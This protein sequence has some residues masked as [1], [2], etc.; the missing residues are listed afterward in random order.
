MS[1]ADRIELGKELLNELEAKNIPVNDNL[2]NDLEH[3]VPKAIV[4]AEKKLANAETNDEAEQ[5]VKPAEEATQSIAKNE[6]AENVTKQ[7][8]KA[9]KSA[10]EDTVLKGVSGIYESDIKD[11][12]DRG[13]NIESY[14]GHLENGKP[15][16][17]LDFE[18]SDDKA[19][20]V[21]DFYSESEEIDTDTSE[22]DYAK[23]LD[24]EQEKK[25]GAEPAEEGN[26]KAT[27]EDGKRSEEQNI[28][29]GLK[30]MEAKKR[31]HEA[32]EKQFT[33]RINTPAPKN[34]P[35]TPEA[36]KEGMNLEYN[37]LQQV[38]K[39]RRA[40]DEEQISYQ[41]AQEKLNAI[42]KTATNTD[43][44]VEDTYTSSNG[45]EKEYTRKSG[46]LEEIKHEKEFL[47]NEH[48]RRH[49]EIEE[50]EKQDR[51]KQENNKYH[52][53][54]DNVS[55]R[56]RGSIIKTLSK[57]FLYKDGYM[58]RKE[59]AEKIASKPDSSSQFKEYADGKK[60]YR[61]FTG[62]DDAFCQC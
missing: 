10:K 53:F 12:I 6:P 17:N 13:Y 57:K 50:K 43:F 9:E 3:G 60:E 20:F 54:L 31:Y 11:Y 19:R 1:R 26:K 49:P 62:D 7:E 61:L 28:H 52:G 38:K 39:V 47:E 33:E 8:V 32:K 40:Y 35:T 29:D 21:K 55:P 2:R 37:F 36:Q 16:Y 18:T 25:A 56:I 45:E 22:P 58:S 59:Y 44:P 14:R 24:E 46:V 41:E 42:E 5:E 23:E 27:N 30:A 34:R 48:R 4:N 15:V 51:I